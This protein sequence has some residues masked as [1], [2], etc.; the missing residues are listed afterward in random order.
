MKKISET[1]TATATTKRNAGSE[2][3]KKI[4][5]TCRIYKEGKKAET[6]LP[7]GLEFVWHVHEILCAYFLMLGFCLF[8]CLCH[9]LNAQCTMGHEFTHMTVFITTTT[10]TALLSSIIYMRLACLRYLDT[11]L[12]RALSLYHTFFSISCALSPLISIE[13]RTMM[14]QRFMSM[15]YVYRASYIYLVTIRMSL[16]NWHVR[17]FVMLLYIY[18]A[19][20]YIGDGFIREARVLIINIES[21]FKIN[22][23]KRFSFGAFENLF[24]C[25]YI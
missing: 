15:Q 10:T 18:K 3:K 1:P 23:H 4:H 9:L 13:C 6:F 11:T 5:N 19:V 21:N 24:K 12:Y 22:T 2:T 8:D 17:F 14:K 20:F 7:F 16:M 25:D